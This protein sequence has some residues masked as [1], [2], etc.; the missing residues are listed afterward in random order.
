MEAWDA[1]VGPFYDER[2]VRILTGLSAVELASHIAS[3]DILAVVTSD[4]ISLFPDFQ[5]GPHGELL[6]GMRSVV[7]LLLPISDDNWDVA[8]WLC[9]SG[10]FDKPSAAELLRMGEIDRVLTIAKRDGSTLDY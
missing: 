7:P 9:A 6:P 8:L 5:F 4:G 1:R 3:S 2:G 10:E